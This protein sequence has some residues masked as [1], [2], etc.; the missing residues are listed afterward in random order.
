MT[1]P[2]H[3]ILASQSPRRQQILREVVSDFEVRTKNTPED[4]DSSTPVLEVPAMLAK[5]KA[6]AFKS[7]LKDNEVVITSDTVVILGNR[8]L[9]KP[10]DASDAKK[11]LTDLSGTLHQVVTGVCLMSNQK[12]VVFHEITEV[13]F[14]PLRTEDIDFYINEY[15]PLDKAGAY[16]IQEFIGYIGIDKIS[17]SYFNVVGL[18]IHRVV[19]ELRSF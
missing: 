3:I 1:F 11:M 16:G 9:G 17:G 12:E 8:I 14:M 10:T 4:F 2:F 18:P 15:K 6:Q 13:S 19:Q 5:R 7:E